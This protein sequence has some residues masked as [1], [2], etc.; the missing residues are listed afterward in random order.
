MAFDPPVLPGLWASFL[1]ASYID[2][3]S[4]MCIWWL[5][6]LLSD[7]EREQGWELEQSDC[8]SVLGY[9]S[10]VSLVSGFTWT[11]STLTYLGP[12]LMGPSTEVRIHLESIPTK[13]STGLVFARGTGLPIRHQ[14]HP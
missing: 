1:R 14:C 8:R 5:M 6:V 11:H 4:S 2:W 7:K 9:R 3:P 12:S 10:Q 13:D